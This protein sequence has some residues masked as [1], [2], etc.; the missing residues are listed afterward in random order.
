MAAL[1][2]WRLRP[3][4]RETARTLA[5]FRLNHNGE[6][7]LAVVV[8]DFF[9]GFDVFLG[10]NVDAVVFLIVLSFGV[11]FTGV[12]DVARG[13]FPTFAVDHQIVGHDKEVLTAPA[14]SF[15]STNP[16]T[17]VLNDELILFNIFARKQAK[18]C[19]T[20]LTHYFWSIIVIHMAASIAGGFKIVGPAGDRKRP[21]ATLA[22][23]V[24]YKTYISTIE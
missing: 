12:V 2:L 14:V 3:C 10:A 6:V 5:A 22:A 18:S 23:L 20:S 9:P 8:G 16:F 1:F 17:G 24:V 11:R 4:F 21:R 7:V 15:L 19:R 13:I